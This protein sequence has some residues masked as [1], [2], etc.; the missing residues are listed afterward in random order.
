[1]NE[2][3]P[4][5]INSVYKKFGNNVILGGVSLAMISGEILGLIGANGIGKTTLLKIIL[6]L[7]KQDSGEVNIQG[8]NSKLSHARKD[9]F[10]LPEKFMPSLLLKGR[11]FLTISTAHFNRSV[12][13]AKLDDLLTILGLDRSILAQNINKYSKG[14]SQKL[15]IIAA[16]L[17][18]ASLLV[19]DEP[20]SGLDPYARIQVRTLF[21][22]HKEESGS[23][24]FTSHILADIDEICDRVA[25]LGGANIQFL[26]SPAMLRSQ[27]KTSNLEEAFLKTAA[28][29]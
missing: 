13:E 5:T 19:L 15:G 27:A 23:I 10:Y 26:G 12:N 28:F 2:A 8:V 6:N 9:L 20:M 1:M 3:S 25:L 21:L 22:R 29:A 7:Q 18:G 14:M 4:I 17:S 24:F 16:F 11:E